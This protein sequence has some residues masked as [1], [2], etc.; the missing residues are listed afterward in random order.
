M[1]TQKKREDNIIVGSKMMKEKI[2]RRRSGE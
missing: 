2:R 1:E